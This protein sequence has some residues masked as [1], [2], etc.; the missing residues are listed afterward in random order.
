MATYLELV[1]KVIAESGKEQNEL[2]E[3]T[4]DSAEAGR[5]L[6]PRIK[7]YVRD[8]W[9]TLQMSR[10]E[11][12]FNNK[13][14][15]VEILPRFLV[16]DI[17]FTPPSDGPDV[18]VTYKGV[19]SGLE[20]TVV[21]VLAGPETDQFYIDFTADGSYNRALLGE[22]FEEVSPNPGDSS[23][24]YRGRGAYRLRDLD[25]LM[26]EPSW[27]TFIGYQGDSTPTPIRFIPWENWL[28]KEISYTTSTRSAPSFVSQDYK[29]DIVFY[30]QTLSPVFVNFVYPTAPQQLVEWD[31][32]PT[33]DLLPAEYHE[34][35]AWI[36]MSSLARFDKDPDLLA[37]AD[38]HIKFYKNRAERNLMPVVRWGASRYNNAYYP[39]RGSR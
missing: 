27:S 24:V 13:E 37:Y 6:Y 31:D 4:W 2:T 33:T 36:A 1:N 3:A 23:F 20:L 5:R 29:G 10:N 35:I 30:P 11:W 16:D 38:E 7:R 26:R 18:G 19:E 22:V 34:W 8:A 17:L 14:I 32:V 25:P 9:E 28:Y 21:E 12:E 15:T 39:I